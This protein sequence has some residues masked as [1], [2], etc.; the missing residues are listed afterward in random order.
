MPQKRRAV[1]GVDVEKYVQQRNDESRRR[2][3]HSVSQLHSLAAQTAAA[4]TAGLDAEIS[5]TI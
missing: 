4:H 2:S 1:T 3:A 5:Q